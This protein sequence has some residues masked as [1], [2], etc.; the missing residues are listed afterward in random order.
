MNVEDKLKKQNGVVVTHVYGTGPSH[1]LRDYLINRVKNLLFIGHPFSYCKDT[2]SFFVRYRQGRIIRQRKAC[3]FR[4]PEILMFFKDIFLTFFWVFFSGEKYDFYVGVNNLNAFVGLVLKKI[5]KVKK[6]VFY[7]IDFVPQRFPN[8]FLNWFYHQIDSFCVK[9]SDWIWNL[10]P[11]MVEEREKKGISLKYRAKQIEVPIGTDLGVKIL[12]FG[13]ISRY[14]IAFMGHLRKGQGLK[15]LIDSLPEIIQE[16]PQAK[17]LL[18]GGGPL[19][20]E[21][22]VEVKQKGLEDQVEV[23]GFIESLDDI[24]KRLAKCA[25]AVAPYE[26]TAFTRYTDPGKV[27]SYLAAGLPV[28]ITRVPKVAWKI[29]REKCGFAVGYNKKDLTSAIVKLLNDEELL[30][31]YKKNALKFAKKYTWDKVFTKAIKESL[32]KS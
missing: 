15:L 7:T 10:S 17:L 18:M 3:P 11:V 22:R 2:S 26:E 5:G 30:K 9:Q 23:T 20:R 13:E 6:V 32:E 28:V 8:K 29:E 25:L 14:T 27:K 24:N 12:P 16:I 19:E 31:V 1:K 21:I 4:F